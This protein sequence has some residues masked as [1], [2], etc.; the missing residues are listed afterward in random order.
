MINNKINIKMII[1]NPKL[2]KAYNIFIG[3]FCNISIIITH[4]LILMSNINDM[5]SKYLGI[6]IGMITCYIISRIISL[7]IEPYIKLIVSDL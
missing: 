3:F 2:Q 4:N 6:S 5:Y 1:N 7:V